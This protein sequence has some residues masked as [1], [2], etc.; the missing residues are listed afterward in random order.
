MNFIID[1]SSKTKLDL[2][3]D[4]SC[5]SPSTVLECGQ[6][7]DIDT[8]HYAHCSH[9]GHCAHRGIAEQR[10]EEQCRCGCTGTRGRRRCRVSG[11]N[12][13]ELLILGLIY[14]FFQVFFNWY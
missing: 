8:R 2:T 5:F 14:R 10:T 13:A 1:Q 12:A 11:Q 4:R 6:F 9:G 7:A 3:T